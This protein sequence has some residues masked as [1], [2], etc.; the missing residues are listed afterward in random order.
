MGI[1]ELKQNPSAVIARV[2]QGETVTLSERGEPV[3]LIIPLPKDPIELL[4]AQGKLLRGSGNF[5]VEDISPAQ[6]LQ[7]SE[8]I[9]SKSRSER[10]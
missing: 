2:K 7:G 6:V 3:A 5:R 1:R 4:I 9:V 8:E 10:I